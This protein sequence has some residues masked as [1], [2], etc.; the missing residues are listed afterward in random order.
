MSPVGL[1][2]R[3]DAATTLGWLTTGAVVGAVVTLGVVFA[4][5][6]LLDR[7]DATEFAP[8]AFAEETL[9]AGIDHRYGGGF[10]FFVG[11]GVAVLDCNDDGFPDIYLA[12]GE[13][14]AAL[15]ENRSAAG[16]ALRFEARPSATTDLTRVTG[17][18]PLDVDSDGI[19]D[20]AVL[21][22]GENVMLRGLGG[23]TFEAAPWGID[24]GNAWTTAFGATWE[25]S[26]ELPTLAY[27]NY[28]SPDG[29]L[30]G[31]CESHQLFRPVSGGYAATGLTPGYCALSML[32]SDWSRSGRRDL[33]VSNDRQYY[34]QG[35]EQL[36]R[37]E[38]GAEPR[39]WTAEEGW[40]PLQING[41]G[42]A[43]HDLTGDGVPEVFLTSIGDNKLQTLAAGATGPRYEDI[44]LER[45]ATAHRPFVGDTAMPSTG[46][47]AEF[48]DVNNDGFIDLYVTKGNVDAM[49]G[50]AMRDPSNLLLGNADGTFTE[51]AGAAGIMS[52]GRGR[53]AA[54]AD[55][56]LDGMLDLIE[57]NRSEPVRVWRNVGSGDDARPE[58]IGDWIA[59]RLSQPGA[60]TDAVGAWVEVRADDRV[61]SR[62]VTIGGGHAG[63]QLGWIHF[64]LGEAESA[65]VRVQW[66]DGE[67]GP[68]VRVD[69]NQFLIIER[70]DAAPRPWTP[71]GMR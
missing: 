65:E 13:H 68:W 58:S 21:R 41:M 24:G 16:A 19:T 40:R 10:D 59:L 20:L 15:Y 61:I 64:G 35:Q 3:R 8:P 26:S 29:Q 6:S 69:A 14:S 12:G 50:A 51:G 22:Y 17:A 28:L 43:S 38:T 23:C 53:G 63:G 32:F 55:L 11:G 9:T 52:L 62:E 1:P 71:A 33:R 30:T 47:H 70:G 2:R 39:L 37:I 60:N 66:P 45:G 67:I 56:N 31:E 42:I 57:V 54:L 4:G 34:R 7:A 48:A 36:W 27:G 49:E 18:Y 25:P 44:A 5:V 46:W